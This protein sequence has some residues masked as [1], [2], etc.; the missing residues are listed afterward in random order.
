MYRKALEVASR[1]EEKILAVEMLAFIS[2]SYVS[3]PSDRQQ[4]ID[5]T[6]AISRR[7]VARQPAVVTKPIRSVLR[8][9]LED[10]MKNARKLLERALN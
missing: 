9:E 8:S 1:H 10:T 7:I 3:S 5:E 6:T 4:S 2:T